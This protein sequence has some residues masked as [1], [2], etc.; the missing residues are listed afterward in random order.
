MFLPSNN[1]QCSIQLLKSLWWQSVS[2]PR[3]PP[4]FASILPYLVSV[5]VRNMRRNTLKL[6]QVLCRKIWSDTKDQI[7]IKR[8]KAILA[9]AGSWHCGFVNIRLVD[10]VILFT[11]R[12]HRTL[13]EFEF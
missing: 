12:F 13:F 10:I 7:F 2:W 8:R 11:E 3:L 6:K 5:E 4:L 1:G 9:V